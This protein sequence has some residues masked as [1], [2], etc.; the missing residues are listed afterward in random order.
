MTDVRV[1]PDGRL[2][3]FIDHPL[4]GD[5]GGDVVVVDATGG[6]PRALS[7]RWSDIA[8][9]AFSSGGD[10]IFFTASRGP[11]PRSVWAVS[12]RRGRERQVERDAGALTLQDVARDGRVLLA[13]VQQRGAI[14]A[15]LPGET[16]ERDLS[17]LDFSSA[18]ALSEDGK[19]IV[20][21][22]SGQGGGAHYGLYV[23]G[24]DGGPAVRIGEGSPLALSAD[25]S[26]VLAMQ[27]SPSRLALLPTGIGEP[28][29]LPGQ[30]DY[31]PLPGAFLPDGKRILFTAREAGRPMR[32]YVQ[33]LAGGAPRALTP[34]GTL[35]WV[36][37]Q[38]KRYV[39]AVG[40]S[41]PALVPVDGGPSRPIAGLQWGDF[42]L[43]WSADGRFLYV[44]R[45]GVPT[46]IL[47]IDPR[48]GA[49]E[50]VRQVAPADPA[51]VTSIT[52]ILIT[53]DF[54]TLVYSY[55]RTLADLYVAE[56]MR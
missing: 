53:P 11:D 16:G 31:Q 46:P 26:Q 19:T 36:M 8:G 34:E 49:R 33:D 44:M 27:M 3:A 40:E 56:G 15:L 13:S 30:L 7:T 43:R 32:T 22:E 20:F 48:T 35:G 37:T 52:N 25:K 18:G 50:P 41:A 17:W 45:S 5:T 10:E 51:G 47:R 54:G 39:T 29:V 23:R 38:D 42:P 12:L 1:S 24:V 28:R 9:L 14:G 6:T 21:S 55:R 4:I 2:V